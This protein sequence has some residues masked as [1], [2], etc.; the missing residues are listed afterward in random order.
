[1]HRTAATKCAQMTDVN[2]ENYC[3][4]RVTFRSRKRLKQVSSGPAQKTPGL[5]K[6]GIARNG[7]SQKFFQICYE[8]RV[9][10][11]LALLAARQLEGPNARLPPRRGRILAGQGVVLVYV[12]ERAIVRRIDRYVRVISPSRVGCSL[13]AGAID[14]RAF[15]ESH[16]A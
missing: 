14:D 10:M 5:K 3:T 12:P 11:S 15:T 4:S 6:L 9:V 16:L 8:V 7:R 1:M 13:H 2:I